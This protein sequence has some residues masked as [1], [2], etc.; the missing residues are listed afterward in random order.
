M[1]ESQRAMV[2]AKLANMKVG[3]KEANASIEAI[4]AVSQYDAATLLNVSR[5]GVQ[6]AKK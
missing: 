6:R 4:G 5:S 2:A 3:G 1:D